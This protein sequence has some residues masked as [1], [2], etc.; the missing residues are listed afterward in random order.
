MEKREDS[1]SSAT[2]PRVAVVIVSFETRELTLRAIESVE[3]STGVDPE[4]W[5]V[6][7]ASTDGTAQAIRVRFPAVRLIAM[8]RNIGF[9][10]ANNAALERTRAPWV[11][12]LN[13]DAALLDDSTLARLVASL[14]ARPR[15]AVVGPLLRT[16]EGR[17]WHSVPPFPSVRHEL[18]RGIGLHLLIPRRALDRWLAKEHRDHGVPGPADW[19]TGACL[20]VRGE[21]LRAIGGFDPA[22]FLYGEDFDLCWRL[23]N[24]GWDVTLDPTVTV[25]H[26]GGTSR[27]LTDWKIRLAVAGEAYV[28]RKHRGR[29]YFAAFALARAAAYTL[30]QM[31]QR[32]AGFL[33]GGE[34]RREEAA[35][36][37]VSLGY[38]LFVLRHGGAR[39]PGS[40][41]FLEAA[42]FRAAEDARLQRPTAGASPPASA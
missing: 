13:P 22:L 27:T 20:L 29:V 40:E 7:N 42:G 30:R 9:G 5:V 2:T 35:R 1:R 32:L 23:R 4:I 16:S 8:E 39:E 10:R 33:G 25:L 15:A 37:R 26:E 18:V 31:L 38:W 24:A 12:L 34:R 19:L 28:V 11:L 36:A 41:R 17:T 21:V 3:R 6:D 14:D